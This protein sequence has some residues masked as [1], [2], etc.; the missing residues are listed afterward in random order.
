[1]LKTHQP[2]LHLKAQRKRIITGSDTC[3]ETLGINKALNFNLTLL[4]ARIKMSLDPFA[5]SIKTFLRVLFCILVGCL[6]ILELFI[7]GDLLLE[8]SKLGLSVGLGFLLR[9]KGLLQSTVLLQV[10]LLCIGIISTTFLDLLLSI[11]HQHLQDRN[12]SSKDNS[13]LALVLADSKSDVCIVT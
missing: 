9:I 1:M 3:K 13:A 4:A 8:V 10:L 12:D 11:F 2:T 7:V 5:I 6:L